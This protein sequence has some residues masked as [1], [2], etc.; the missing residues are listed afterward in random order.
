MTAS[1][2][3]LVAVLGQ[4]TQPAGP[5][6]GQPGGPPL[7][8]RRI[9]VSTRPATPPRP[10]VLPIPILPTTTRPGVEVRVAPTGEQTVTPTT[11]PA[12][13]GAL[14]SG[15]TG[16]RVEVE[17]LADGSIV[18]RGS[19]EDVAIWQR[20]IAQLEAEP[21]VRPVFRV[22]RLENAQAATLASQIRQVWNDA[23]RPTVGA[24]R[25]EDQVNI[26][27]EPRANLLMVATAEKNI[28]EIAS[29]IRELDQ[30]LAEKDQPVLFQP[31]PLKHI[32]ANEAEAAVRDLLKDLQQRRNA[33]GAEP[34]TIRADMRTNSLLVSASKGDFEQIR[35]LVELIDVP[36]TPGISAV[37][38]A[39][40]P[41]KQAVASDLVGA[42][43]EILTA[44][45]T[46][47]RTSQAAAMKEQLRRLQM[48]LMGPGGAK[49]LPDLDLERQIR[50]FA[51]EGTNSVIVATS[52]ENLEP[53]RALIELLDSVPLADEIHVRIFPLRFA[54]AE[55]LLT[56]LKALFDP[57]PELPELPGR[58]TINDRVPV[59]AEGR[60]LAYRIT[61][62]AHKGTNT[63][64]AAGR[65]EQLALVENIINKV[66]VREGLGDLTPRLVK[67]EHSDVKAIADVLQ[68]LADQRQRVSD[69]VGPN[70]ALRRNILIIPDQRTNSLVI[71]AEP[72]TYEE[73]AKLARELDGSPNR[74]A[75]QFQIIPLE[76]LIAADLVEKMGDLWKRRAQLRQAANLPA[77]DPVIVADAR[78]NSLIVSANPEDVEAL[79]NLVKQLERQKISPMMEI[80]TLVIRHNDPARVADTLRSIFEERLQ[81]STA[82]GQQEQ[83]SERVAIVEDPLT[84]TLLIASNKANYDEIVR[85]VNQL[86]KPPALDSV[87]R[88]FFIRN[89]N[90][91]RLAEMINDLFTGGVYQG[92]NVPRDLPEALTRVT[93]VAD[94][95]SRA[96]IVSASPEN[97]AI[98]EKLV[99]QVD[100][101]D[102]PLLTG[103]AQFFRIENGD[104]VRVADML[105]QAL[106]GIQATLED[107][108]Q[109]QYVVVPD[110]RTRSLMVSGT[111]DAI[112]QAEALVPRLDV[113][114]GTPA[115][116]PRVYTLQLAS[117]RQ[118]APILTELFEQRER[119]GA[120][121]AQPARTTPVL[122]QSVEGTNSLIVT[123][124]P[125][126]HAFVQELLKSLDVSSTMSQQMRV[127]PLSQARAEG[128][129]DTLRELLQEQ[130]R[131]R[132]GAPP[133]AVTPEARTNS[134]I[135]FAPPDL[136]NNIAQIIQSLDTTQPVTDMA[137]RVFKLR[138]AE[139]EDMAE[140][141]REF[142]QEA[143]GERESARRMIITFPTKERDPVT[144]E[145]VQKRLVYQDVTLTPDPATNS[146]MVLA[147]RDSMDMMAHLV[148]MLDSVE[149]RTAQVQI[150]HLQ[151]EDAEE[152]RDTLEELF[153]AGTTGGR[154]GAGE[155]ATRLQFPGEGGVAIGG[156]G[157]VTEMAFATDRRTNSLLA[158]G[159]QANLRIVERLVLELDSRDIPDRKTRVVH[160][161]YAN[162]EDVAE[163]LKAYFEEESQVV[164]AAAGSAGEAPTRQLERRVTVEDAGETQNTL[165]LAYSP[166]LEAQIMNI[167]DELDLPPPQVMIQVLM[168][169]ITLDNRLEMGMEFALQDLNFSEHSYLNRNNILQGS[170]FD[171]IFGVD[172]GA[173]GQSSLGGIS[174][175]IT[176]E[177]FNFL[178]RA[179]QTEG[180]LEVLS[181][182]AIMVQDN[183]DANIN[184]GSRVPTIQDINIS[185]T[186]FVT[187]SVSYENVGVI[188]DVTPIINP[189][190]FV[191]LKIA[192]EI[193][194]I[195]TSSVT[196]ASGVSLPVF[197]TRSAETS[198]TVKDGE[199]IIIGGLITNRVNESENKVP[200][201]GDIPLLGNLFRATVKTNSKTE[202]LMVLTPHV[203]RDEADARRISIQMRDQTGILGDVRR[204]P[205]M[206]KLQDKAEDHCGPE[207]P[208]PFG[209]T[210]PPAEEYGPIPEDYGPPAGAL[211]NNGARSDTATYRIGRSAQ[212]TG[213]V[214]VPAKPSR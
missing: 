11:M 189:D 183:Q 93:V 199:T 205:L 167:I 47:G 193:S 164:E 108:K 196:V 115:A 111:R 175:T 101:T 43:N 17:V 186:G 122:V 178:V 202:L 34:A 110:P 132:E 38:L 91:T 54:D 92:P 157:G 72:E 107:A 156:E 198:V 116:Q 166:R 33:P 200:L 35:K 148:E 146:L 36:P 179:L 56:N 63:L 173:Q 18:L 147:P 69:A 187:P 46:T 208:A 126:D 144:G 86:D 53:M 112:K 96:L 182:P 203:I 142:F 160:L 31:I 125:E 172:L 5:T 78:T 212:P 165:V 2:L 62:A 123:A 191:N 29:L 73:M 113:A 102:M 169:E 100:Q 209:P 85:L 171:N 95:R 19:P 74:F 143:A 151:N 76:N 99:Q 81:N 80:R 149:L 158:A 206:G 204:S 13:M 190:G 114:A 84:R 10:S 117:A 57:G 39:I 163:T 97:I 119:G 52:E 135:V 83:V 94:E 129:A 192:P 98:V 185:S 8:G 70:I 184:V 213:P 71:V 3:L 82:A 32:K 154:R 55:T 207:G 7:G 153:Q 58:T 188:L 120:G 131:G 211:H 194:S 20:F 118:L 128:L 159:S 176:G 42:I 45:P 24:A 201:L 37:K 155:G 79:N 180:R 23:H 150:F 59:N 40:F 137:L 210:A 50:V 60:A 44:E 152:M 61:F 64:I 145:P 214:L 28:D 127:F 181:R 139:A 195:G 14:L 103:S 162:A 67:L 90:V 130:L 51:E 77:D 41:L 141:L 21:G 89:A 49:P 4:T 75:G 88:T 27:A 25:P 48:I 140:R 22:F 121:A 134:L 106:K 68:K 168:A 174:F 138:N 6:A 87:I 1:V 136:M 66:D 177:D 9:T 109:L 12:D 105:D 26:V 65:T 197:E 30:P 15:L 16:D 104:V 124:S 170:G 133:V 161:R